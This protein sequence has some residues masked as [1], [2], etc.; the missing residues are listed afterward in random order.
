MLKPRRKNWM[1]SRLLVNAK[2]S[3]RRTLKNGGN[4]MSNKDF[5]M[6][7]LRVSQTML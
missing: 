4:S 3:R 2:L 7:S 1:L 5:S 6:L